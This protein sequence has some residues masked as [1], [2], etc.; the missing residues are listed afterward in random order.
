MICVLHDHCFPEIYISILT[1][2]I[3]ISTCDLFLNNNILI[4]TEYNILSSIF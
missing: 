1:T 2:F 4:N 3:P